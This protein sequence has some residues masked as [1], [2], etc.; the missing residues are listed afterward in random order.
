MATISLGIGTIFSSN[1]Y[2]RNFYSSNRNAATPSNRKDYTA[3][4]LSHADAAALR[5]A[6]KELGSFSYDTSER[7]NIQNSARA[8]IDTYNNLLSSTSTAE[9]SSI[10]RNTKHLKSLTEN[11]ADELDKAG[12]TVNSDG[13]LT[14]R[15]A[16]AT[17]GTISRL[18]KIFSSDS[19]YMQNAASYAKR[20]S[21]RSEDLSLLEKRKKL[22]G[23]AVSDEDAND[24][25]PDIDTG[26]NPV[27]SSLVSDS[28]NSKDF[29]AP[30][31]GTTINISL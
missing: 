4:E 23:A 20:I 14:A 25:S 16:F 26:T 24:N 19:D 1:F 18:K 5:R 21:N 13:T 3:N 6:V 9:D 8:Y 30:G 27:M 11:Y 12:I 31:V 2:K 29:L 15:D 7:A 22:A 28:F 10:I 17:T